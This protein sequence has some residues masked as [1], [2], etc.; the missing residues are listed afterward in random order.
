MKN[1]S[2]EI[3]SGRTKRTDKQNGQTKS[4]L[5][6]VEFII[7]A[8]LCQGCGAIS[9]VPD[10]FMNTLMF[11]A[12]FIIYIGL[13]LFWMQSVRNR[14]LPTKA[15]SYIL[16]AAVFMLLYLTLRAFKYRTARNSVDLT[17]YAVYAYWIPQ[18]LIPTLFLTACICFR[19]WGGRNEK[20]NELLLLIPA[21][22]LGLLVMTNDLHG[23]VYAPKVEL[24]EFAANTVKHARGDSL[25]VEISGGEGSQV[26]FITNSGE[27]PAAPIAESGGLLSLR[28][29]IEEQGGR[30]TVQ[31][32]PF[33][34]LTIYL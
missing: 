17:R 9:D 8:G 11:S 30:M 6:F 2:A 12:N 22:A 28:R 33:F 14:L 1:E 13:L 25:T 7:L 24:S 29:R 18:L 15:R 23:F 27:P 5:L 16:A 32:L 20:R 21:C 19:R 34:S 3:K 10:L 31:S 26:I 4:V